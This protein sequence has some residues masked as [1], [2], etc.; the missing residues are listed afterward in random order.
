MRL[1]TTLDLVRLVS[2]FEP[3][4]YFLPED[5]HRKAQGCNGVRK[6]PLAACWT[7]NLLPHEGASACDQ[8]YP[9]FLVNQSMG[10]GGPNH[11]CRFLC[12]SGKDWSCFDVGASQCH[13]R[14]E[15]IAPRP[16]RCRVIFRQ[17]CLRWLAW[18]CN[19]LAWSSW[20]NIRF[21]YEITRAISKALPRPAQ[22]E[23]F[24][25]SVEEHLGNRPVSNASSQ[26]ST[27]L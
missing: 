18:R 19:D 23:H 8:P 26:L 10:G 4:S 17:G 12:Q 22:G 6:E 25:S 20:R 5:R 15:M 27:L 1:K 14:S 2:G 13:W 16:N 9:T 7:P 3:P 24:E 21:I 11:Y